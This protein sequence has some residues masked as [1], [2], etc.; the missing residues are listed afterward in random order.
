MKASVKQ[1]TDSSSIPL[2]QLNGK[3]GSPRLAKSPARAAQQVQGQ[4]KNKDS[5]KHKDELYLLVQ[6]LKPPLHTIVDFLDLLEHQG[7]IKGEVTEE[8][9][10]MIKHGCRSISLLIQE[11]LQI[12]KLE[13]TPGQDLFTSFDLCTSTIQA[14][15]SMR[16]CLIQKEL[17][18]KC[19][20]PTTQLFSQGNPDWALQVLSNIIGNAINYSPPKSCLSIDLEQ[21]PHY[22][23]VSVTDEG[24]GISKSEQQHLFHK[25]RQL[26]EEQISDDREHYGSGL[27][28]AKILTERMQGKL[29]CESKL[30]KGTRFILEI[31]LS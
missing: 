17:Y 4:K 2:V 6:D 31:P 7:V 21:T 14:L 12:G 24:P 13:L 30:G 18:L 5:R 9:F 1:Q 27:Y 28:G 20:F 25:F 19:Q 29:R 26:T 15:D 23:R 16:N 11:I 8:S 10:T 3:T 22:N